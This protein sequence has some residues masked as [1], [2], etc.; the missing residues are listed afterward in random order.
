[1]TRRKA[2]TLTAVTGTQPAAYA[3]LL[4][5]IKERIRSAQYEALKAI[6]KELVG[7]YWDIGRLIVER[8][9]RT[10]LGE[11]VVEKLS[12][13]VPFREKTPTIGWRN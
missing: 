10:S 13:D 1:M 6:N 5:E 4:G 9:R 12:A 3:K 2:S 8:Q 11:S 7:L